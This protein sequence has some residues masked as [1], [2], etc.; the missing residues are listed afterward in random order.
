MGIRNVEAG[1]DSALM[2]FQGIQPSQFLAGL[3]VAACLSTTW[4]GDY[5]NSVTMLRM[6]LRDINI[7]RTWKFLDSSDLKALYQLPGS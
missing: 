3:F 2:H 7:C 6:E 4:T 1:N 5:P